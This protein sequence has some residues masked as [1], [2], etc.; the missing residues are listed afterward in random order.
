MVVVT[1]SKI[2]VHYL[3]SNVTPSAKR[4][5]REA[6]IAYVHVYATLCYV[7]MGSLGVCLEGR[8]LVIN[9]W[10]RFLINIEASIASRHLDLATQL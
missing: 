10:T 4:R 2:H 5:R 8:Q 9:V 3:E 6:M 7:A 1:Q